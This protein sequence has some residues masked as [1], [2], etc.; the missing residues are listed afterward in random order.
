MFCLLLCYRCKLHHQICI[1]SN[2]YNIININLIFK[3][4]W[5][6]KQTKNREKL[7]LFLVFMD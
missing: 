1:F 6:S 7:K 2:I 4:Q 5:S 3:E